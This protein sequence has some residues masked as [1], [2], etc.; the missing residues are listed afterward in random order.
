MSGTRQ[1]QRGSAA[2]GSPLL[3][4]L[5]IA[6]D[7]PLFG[8]MLRV[9]G[10]IPG[11][12]RA[13]PECSWQPR[14]VGA[15]MAPL[16]DG[17]PY[18]QRRRQRSA[19]GADEALQPEEAHKRPRGAS[20]RCLDTTHVA[21]CELCSPAP[22]EAT[23]ENY[24]LVGDPGKVRSCSHGT[25]ARVHAAAALRTD[26]PVYALAVP[27]LRTHDTQPRAPRKTAR[28]SCVRC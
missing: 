21:P 18:A 23:E 16:T 28:R 3:P 7:D 1:Q 14:D 15:L 2:L 25:R 19:D 17:P 10:G 4:S 27:G 9:V 5:S 20:L 13:S 22:E 11:D 24:Q 12:G 8:E 26:C 6:S